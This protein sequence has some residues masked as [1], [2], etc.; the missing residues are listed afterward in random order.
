MGVFMRNIKKTGLVLLLVFILVFSLGC[1]KQEKGDFYFETVR[2][3]TYFVNNS[4]LHI[5]FDIILDDQIGYIEKFNDG[6]ID[7]IYLVELIMSEVNSNQISRGNSITEVIVG[8]PI[9]EI[10]FSPGSR[11]P[12]SANGGLDVSLYKNYELVRFTSFTGHFRNK[13]GELESLNLQLHPKH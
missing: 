7:E 9:Y 3:I 6:F 11:L 10:T 1:S 2:G 12:V 13:Q 8:H 4:E 5:T